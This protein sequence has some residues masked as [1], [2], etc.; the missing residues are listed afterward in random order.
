M[1]IVSGIE[2]LAVLMRCD[3][4]PEA[5]GDRGRDTAQSKKGDMNGIISTDRAKNSRNMPYQDHIDLRIIG[6]TTKRP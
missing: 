5:I 3:K 6:A 1:P 4:R 2:V